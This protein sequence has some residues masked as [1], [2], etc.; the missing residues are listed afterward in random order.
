MNLAPMDFD[1]QAID[2]MYDNQYRAYPSIYDW[3]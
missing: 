1:A 3:R 2:P